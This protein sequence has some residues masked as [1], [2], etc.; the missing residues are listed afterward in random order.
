MATEDASLFEEIDEELKHDRMYANLKK[1]KNS[2]ITG[3]VIAV[4]GIVAYSSW[5]SQKQDKLEAITTTLVDV[6]RDPGSDKSVKLV[7][8]FA[9]DA[10][11]EIK[12]LLVILKSGRHIQLSKAVKENAEEL[13]SLVNKEGVD[14]VWK[15]L[16]LLI[17]ASH[18]LLKEKNL[19]ATLDPLTEENRPFKFMAMELIAFWYF[20]EKQ[21][22]KALQYFQ[23]ILDHEDA[24]KT[25]KN[26]IFMILNHIKNKSEK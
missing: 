2:I 17:C 1:H 24:P 4:F 22:E 3:L 5:Y 23:K 20:N 18:N 16:A 10:P 25:L 21:Q 11:S 8:G 9:E 12:P 19:V 13:L 7:D 6:L 15:D 26:R 14:I